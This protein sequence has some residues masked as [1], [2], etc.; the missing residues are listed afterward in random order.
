M[1]MVGSQTIGS[2]AVIHVRSSLQEECIAECEKALEE[3]L[4][5]SR[6]QLVINLNECPLIS[7]SGLE[8]IVD[9]QNECLRRGGKLIVA[10]PQSLCAEILTITGVDQ[11]VSVYRDMRTALTDFAR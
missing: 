1:T 8:F 11:H 9:A 5:N 7:S 3:A 4:G 2:V 10:E 6:Q